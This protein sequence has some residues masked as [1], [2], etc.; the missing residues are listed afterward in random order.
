MK[1]SLVIFIALLAL[2]AA[3]PFKRPERRWDFNGKPRTGQLSVTSKDNLSGLCDTVEQQAGY[4]TVGG[5]AQDKHYF[6]WYFES[7]SSPSTDPVLL[8]MTG[9]PGCSSE[10]ALL[11]E[12][13]PCQ[14]TSD[15]QSTVINPFSWNNQSNIIYI[16]QPTGVGF[17]Y[18]QEGDHN[19]K[20]VA[21]DMYQFLH[22][23]FA[24]KPEL[25]NR[26]LYIFG[27]SYGGHF[28]PATA[29]RV[30]KSLNLAGL[31]VGNGLTDPL[32]QYKYY[33]EMA[34]TYAEQKIGKPVISK[35]A[36][37]LMNAEFPHCK[38]LIAKCQNDT[39]SCAQA[40][41]YCNTAMVAPY[42]RT[43]R[44]V[45]D[46]RVPCGPNPLCYDITPVQTFLN[47]PSTLEALGVHNMKK[48][49]PC[50]YTVNAAFAYDWMK[51]FQ[52][53]V[54]A[55]LQNETR[56]LIYAG[57]VD[58]ICNWIGN[59]AWTMALDWTGHDGFNGATDNEWY[60]GGKSAGQLRTYLNFSFLRV[61][62]AGHM[63]PHDQP[64]VALNMVSQFFKNF[65][66]AKKN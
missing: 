7:R 19:E 25:S 41:A 35:L 2:A 11:F 33:P 13:G 3:S 8:W 29:A 30:G 20:E 54:T 47:L 43:G 16:D 51:D 23:F 36:Y 58:F 17:S 31:A 10:L 4:F 37:E 53:D 38:D 6:Y 50:N 18:G 27:E 55:L 5:A 64:A 66:S 65:Q 57:D 39:Q 44:N 40:Q 22:E 49:S 32:I 1:V 45:Y 52:K 14:P 9:G 63:V 15:G 21:E 60:V 46:I 26:E 24:S 34:Y 42:E 59:K 28:A 12:N 48:W 56:V 61:Y 62:D